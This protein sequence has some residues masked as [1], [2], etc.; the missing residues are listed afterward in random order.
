MAPARAAPTRTRPPTSAPVAVRCPTGPLADPV[1]RF[2]A[3]LRDPRRHQCH[4]P[5]PDLNLLFV[6]I[7]NLAA[8]RAIERYRIALLPTAPP[9]L[10]A[11]LKSEEAH[12]CDLS[13]LLFICIG[14]A[15]LSHEV[16][17]R[18]AAI[19]PN[20]EPFQVPYLI[21]YVLLIFSFIFPNMDSLFFFAG[22]VYSFGYHGIQ[23]QLLK[24]TRFSPLC[25]FH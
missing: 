14:G 4:P 13:S 6:S 12:R 8:L 17:E 18:F 21:G 20:I 9:V 25:Y 11:M 1:N 24:R 2:E 10:V 3:P 7:F 15:P 22:F 23:P 5:L 16:A 19:F